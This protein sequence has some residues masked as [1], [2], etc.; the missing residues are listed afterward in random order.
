MIC[1]YFIEIQLSF[2]ISIGGC[3]GVVV[4]I[5]A[6]PVVIVPGTTMLK[7]VL[8]RHELSPQCFTIKTTILF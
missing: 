6:S 4:K 1:D 7:P 8:L 3:G 5:W 2:L